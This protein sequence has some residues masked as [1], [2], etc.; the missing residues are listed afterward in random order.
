MPN[1]TAS[2]GSSVMTRDL[3]DA[4]YLRDQ[5]ID[6]YGRR[7]ATRRTMPLADMGTA[8]AAGGSVSRA[9][10]LD[11]RNAATAGPAC[12]AEVSISQFNTEGGSGA[13]VRPLPWSWEFSGNINSESRGWALWAGFGAFDY[14]TGLLTNVGA[15]I[16]LT[17]NHAV[18]SMNH[19]GTTFV[20]VTNGTFG[21]LL[22]HSRLICSYRNGVM[23]T[24]LA[25]TVVTVELPAPV[26]VSSITNTLVT[27]ATG[28]LRFR[29]YV[30]VTNAS[31]AVAAYSLRNFTINEW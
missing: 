25:T 9:G 30:P 21:V 17:T 5:A 15:G 8:T 2:A 28:I 16:L 29:A 14:T 31:G 6:E 19:N 22:N 18:V 26:L 27:D 3:G 4:R 20:S 12:F 13:G 1:Q 23:N 11:L 10:Y 24:Y 7:F